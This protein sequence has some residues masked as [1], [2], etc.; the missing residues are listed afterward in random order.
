MS[1][2]YRLSENS[3]MVNDAQNRPIAENE[4]VGE[5]LKREDVI[6]QPLSKTIFSIIDAIFIK[7]ERI[8]EIC[9]IE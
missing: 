3:F 7:N 1:L 4:L 5:A 2:V 8:R 6:G 9:P